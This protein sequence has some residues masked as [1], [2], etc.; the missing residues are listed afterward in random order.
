[1][2]LLD[3]PLDSEKQI[4]NMLADKFWPGPLTIIAKAAASIPMTVT[5]DTGF[6]GKGAADFR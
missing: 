4:V 3:L 6:V 1:V 2:K 5:A